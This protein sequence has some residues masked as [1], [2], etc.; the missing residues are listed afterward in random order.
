[1]LRLWALQHNKGLRKERGLRK[2]KL[3]CS[4]AQRESIKRLYKRIQDTEGR[5]DDF[6]SEDELHDLLFLLLSPQSLQGLSEDYIA[7]P[8]DQMLFL[9]SLSTHGWRTAAQIYERC[10]ALQVAF[11]CIMVRAA[12][13]KSRLHG[14]VP[15]KDLVPEKVV[16]DFDQVAEA[17]F[18]EGGCE[19]NL[20]GLSI[21]DSDDLASNDIG[22]LEV[23]APNDPILG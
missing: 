1:M 6:I 13:R 23:E 2:L 14:T 19:G 18:A 3:I 15:E 8:T 21:T 7:C 16:I 11:Q 17:E 4:K 5:L 22:Q 12:H 9:F 10:G 20:N